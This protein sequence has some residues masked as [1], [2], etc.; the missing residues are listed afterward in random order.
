MQPGTGPSIQP[1]PLPAARSEG[2]SGAVAARPADCRGG[3]A[4]EGTLPDGVGGPAASFVPP[5]RRIRTGRGVGLTSVGVRRV[6]MPWRRQR[7]LET[8]LT[9]EVSDQPGAADRGGAR[10]PSASSEAGGS[11]S[12]CC[13]RYWVGAAACWGT[14]LV[15]RS[16]VSVVRSCR[17]WNGRCVRGWRPRAGAHGG[18]RHRDSCGGAARALDDRVSCSRPAL[19]IRRCR[20]TRAPATAVLPAC[21]L[22]GVL[23]PS[24][25]AVDTRAR[26][27]RAPA[28]RPDHR[29][30]RA[31]ARPASAPGVSGWRHRLPYADHIAVWKVEP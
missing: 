22:G 31:F 13:S 27:A 21:G 10:D 14:S 19:P 17:L 11:T 5:A 8:E 29:G 28:R 20:R 23:A 4:C 1:V 6:A 24:P 26:S 12:A 9:R 2:P 7:R 16:R 18:P 15:R 30:G 3:G 25:A